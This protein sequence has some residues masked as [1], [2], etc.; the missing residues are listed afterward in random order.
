MLQNIGYA[1]NF[2][3]GY[4]KILFV[5]LQSNTNKVIQMR[6]ATLIEP[7]LGYRNIILI[8]KWDT[9]WEVEICGSG[10]HIWVYEDEFIED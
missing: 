2:Y 3:Y 4:I 7:Y 5:Y 8:E 1:G 9:K 10:K 6:T